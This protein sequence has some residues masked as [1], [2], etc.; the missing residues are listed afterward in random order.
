MAHTG[1][2]DKGSWSS[3]AFQ[4]DQRSVNTEKCLGD[5]KGTTLL[6]KTWECP[7]IRGTDYGPKILRS[8]MIR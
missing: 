8:L 1:R 3:E 5:R 7:K 6:L 2:N 4:S